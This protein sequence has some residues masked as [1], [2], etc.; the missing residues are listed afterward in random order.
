VV[1]A[2]LEFGVSPGI[3]LGRFRSEWQDLLLVAVTELRDADE[4]DRWAR[5]LRKAGDAR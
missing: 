2:G 1:E 3:N 4:I 5:A